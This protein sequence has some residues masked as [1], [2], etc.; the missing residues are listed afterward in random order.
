VRG[1]RVRGFPYARAIVALAKMVALYTG[2]QL[3]K[4]DVR[5]SDWERPLD[6][7]QRLCASLLPLCD[8]C[9]C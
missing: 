7:R 1:L 5:T 4:D 8:G 9:V 2:R 6:A 3:L